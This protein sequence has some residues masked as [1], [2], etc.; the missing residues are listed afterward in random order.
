MYICI[1]IYYENSPDRKRV[2]RFSLKSSRETIVKSN[3]HKK[4]R[5]SLLLLLLLLFLLLLLLLLSLS[6]YDD[7]CRAI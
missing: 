2:L 5:E 1:C 4:K 6:L 3:Y 7:T